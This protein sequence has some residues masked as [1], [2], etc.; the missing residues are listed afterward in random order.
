MINI[1]YVPAKFYTLYFV[2]LCFTF[3]KMCFLESV[4]DGVGSVDMVGVHIILLSSY[5]YK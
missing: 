3:N 4:V 1:S 5:K 2:L